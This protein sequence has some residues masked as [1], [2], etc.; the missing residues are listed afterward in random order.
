MKRKIAMGEGRDLF[1]FG[2]Y[3]KF[4]SFHSKDTREG[5]LNFPGDVSSH[6]EMTPLPP[7][8]LMK[9]KTWDLVVFT[10]SSLCQTGNNVHSV[11][12][13][14]LVISCGSLSFPP[15]GNKIGT[16]TVY[17]ATAIFTCNSGYTLVGSHVRECLANGLWSGP[18]T[19]CLG[20]LIFPRALLYF[21]QTSKMENSKTECGTSR[22]ESADGE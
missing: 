13:S 20:E 16:L 22:H 19:R 7:R 9:M 2:F 18:E 10:E 15:N 17:G 4:S 14:L 21:R 8:F 12:L 3:S 11:F 6:P 1:Y 5:K